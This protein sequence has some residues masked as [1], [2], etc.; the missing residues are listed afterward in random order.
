MILIMINEYD[1]T[2]INRKHTEGDLT[3][4]IALR[5]YECITLGMDD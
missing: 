3:S 4:T 1:N 5:V 2:E